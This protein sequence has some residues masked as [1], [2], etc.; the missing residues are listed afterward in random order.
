MLRKLASRCSVV[1]IP[2]VEDKI[3]AR[4]VDS[5]HDSTASIWC[6][7]THVVRSWVWLAGYGKGPGRELQ[8]LRLDDDKH[9]PRRGR[10]Y[11]RRHSCWKRQFKIRNPISAF[12]SRT[13]GK[14]IPRR[15][16]RLTYN[17]L[18][19]G[20][21]LGHPC[22]GFVALDDEVEDDRPPKVVD[23]DGAGCTAK[24]SGAC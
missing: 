23:H 21:E 9:C 18:L 4:A 12:A 16:R 8:A 22:D 7:E 13:T 20:R 2:P 14:I 5:P 19:R 10:M 24:V 3:W 15:T 6:I 17:A 11:E 1:R